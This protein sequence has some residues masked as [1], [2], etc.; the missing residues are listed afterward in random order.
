MLVVRIGCMN[1]QSAYW[2]GDSNGEE[3]EV[4]NRTYQT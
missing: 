3:L 2:D 4:R 1:G